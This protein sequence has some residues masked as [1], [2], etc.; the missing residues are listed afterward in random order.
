MVLNFIEHHQ[1]SSITTNFRIIQKLFQ[2]RIIKSKS[3]TSFKFGP[4]PN[5]AANK[6]MGPISSG[7]LPLHFLLS[8]QI[9]CYFVSI[10]SYILYFKSLHFC[11]RKKSKPNQVEPATFI[12]TKKLSIKLTHYM[13]VLFNFFCN[14]DQILI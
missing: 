1:V 14:S 10:N 13:N 9:I 12:W 8:T 4:M 2:I 7:Y 3:T 11:Y 5:F 6:S